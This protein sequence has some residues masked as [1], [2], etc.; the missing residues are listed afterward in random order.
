V[1]ILLVR[2]GALGDVILT[3]PVVQA[4]HKQSAEATIEMI[5]NPAVLRLLCGRSSVRAV[6]S[7]DALSIEP[8][9]QPNMLPTPDLSDRFG[10]YDVIINYVGP[11]H[12]VF[13]RSLSRVARGQVIDCDARPSR[14]MPMH[15]S[16]FLQQPLQALGVPSCSDPPRLGLTAEDRQRAASWWAEEKLGLE[17]TVALHLGSGSPAKNWP[18]ERFAAVARRLIAG[19]NQVLLVGGPADSAPISIVQRELQGMAFTQAIDL[20]LSLVAAILER[21]TAYVGNDSG[22]SHL[23]AAVGVPVVAI[24]G[25]TDPGVWAPRGKAVTVLQG[26]IVNTAWEVPNEQLLHSLRAVPV[27]TA[28]EALRAVAGWPLAPDHQ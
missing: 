8:M 15:M 24:F 20:P 16:E 9:F 11:A 12:A 28:M 3:L 22:I 26:S 14:H 10:A 23:A 1:R 17:G 18:A 21:C 6:W 13:T 27:E 5:G 2:P 4:L 7:F 25:P 19:G